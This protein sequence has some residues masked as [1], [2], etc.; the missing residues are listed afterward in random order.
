MSSMTMARAA[1]ACVTATSGSR[2]LR[3]RSVHACRTLI[4]PAA[5]PMNLSR[6]RA[7]FQRLLRTTWFKLFLGLLFCLILTLAALP[8]ALKAGLSYWLVQNGAEQA[9]IDRFFINPFLGKLSL[10]GLQVDKDGKDVLSNTRFDLDL[11]LTDLLRRQIHVQRAVYDKL[12]L[13]L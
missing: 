7:W 5:T 3:A 12:H 2:R 1:R 4:A 9:K 10:Q 6:S 11:G 13:D 8:F